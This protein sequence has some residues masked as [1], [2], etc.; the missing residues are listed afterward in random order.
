M[1]KERGKRKSV[2]VEERRA[3]VARLFL[4]GMPQFKIVEALGMER[5]TG[6][7]TVSTDI[8]HIREEW[9]KGALRDFDAAKEEQLQKLKYLE[10]ELWD[11]WHTSKGEHTSTSVTARKVRAAKMGSENADA[12][13]IDDSQTTSVAKAKRDPNGSFSAQIMQI[14]RDQNE[15][16]GITAK[17]AAESS[18]PPVISFKIHRPAEDKAAPAVESA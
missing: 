1:P 2:E 11:A 17:T 12:T 10:S 7:T 8:K 13:M 6:D 18:S 16:L 4:Q 9:K 15:L 14:I 3:K 5:G